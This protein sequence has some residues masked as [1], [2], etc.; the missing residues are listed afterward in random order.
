[1]RL[2]LR[3]LL[4][5]LDNTLD[6]QDAEIL[7]SKLA[8]SG[9]ATQ[10]V[11]RI[12]NLLTRSDLSAPSPLARGPVEEANV[13]C[14]YLDSTL[15]VEQVAEV[16]RACLDSDPHLA[17]A[18]ACHQILTMALENPANV[19]VVLRDRIYQ[20][21]S[22][23][24]RAAETGGSF[25]ALEIPESVNSFDS[26][27]SHV[28]SMEVPPPPDQEPVRPAG[29]SDSGVMAAPARF[30]QRE[31]E[32]DRAAKT[33]PA[34]AGSR[35][36]NRHTE[37]SI[38][39][40][41]VRPSRI[42][43]WLVTLG[44]AGVLLYAL[45]QIF[46]PLLKSNGTADTA[47]PNGQAVT[48]EEDDSETPVEK[49][50][51]NEGSSKSASGSGPTD[52]DLGNAVG[53]AS[54]PVVPDPASSGEEATK[55]GD[56]NTDIS[57]GSEL[58]NPRPEMNPADP[59]VDDAENPKPESAPSTDSDTESGDLEK[60]PDS[61]VASP[62]SKTPEAMENPAG[63]MEKD[64]SPDD[65][66][67][68]PSITAQVL[69]EN[70]LLAVE[71][72]G[73]WQRLDK[74]ADVAAGQPLVVAPGFRASLAFADSEVTLLGPAAATLLPNGKGGLLVRLASGRLLVSSTTPESPVELELGDEKYSLELA[75]PE[76]SAAIQLGHT[77]KPSLDPLLAENHVPVRH[78]I[79]LKG[80]VK[81]DFG[82]ASQT[83]DSGSQ[84]TQ[85]GGGEPRVE[86]L[87]AVPVWAAE[88][89]AD[90]NSLA[91]TARNDLLTL[92]DGAS[93]LEIGL[94]ELLGFRRSEVAALAAQT[95][96]GLGRS[97]VYFG[98]AGVFN[99]LK[100]RAYWSQHYDALLA[101]VDS[102][103]ESA[104]E[105]QQAIKKMDA[106]AEL[107]LFGML[108]GYTDEQ[109]ASGSDRQLL[110]NLDS[111]DM[112]VRVLAFENL[113]RITGVTFNYR[114]EQDSQGRREQYLKRW[115]V[116]QRKG[117]I[118]WKK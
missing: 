102:G 81:I 12:R 109:L 49:V 71:K 50:A 61:A 24:K 85:V 108:T 51:A 115:Q 55:A 5:Y 35:P 56:A 76:T 30:R 58:E 10:M 93:S 118:R 103:V 97:D 116:L 94:R 100:Q 32:D 19:T 83:L 2:T 45:S 48:G 67:E 78:V 20:L 86:V 77:R 18:A 42:T 34:I 72:E 74:D 13:I 6:P 23:Q 8:E 79:A 84:W 91:V 31:L 7:K 95:L 11:Q 33:E 96:L 66:G 59:V 28:L 106:A 62:V 113:R 43:P 15:P 52:S 27:S 107:Q 98:G 68:S 54:V 22:E 40:G 3:T 80:A 75:T 53:D 26:P 63:D 21:P 65:E 69:S 88:P 105:V 46:Q 101:R 70:T 29:V 17:E 9:F 1:M 44:L 112:S 41:Q 39:G 25:S 89:V 111:A 64:D 114:A 104:A 99:D 14:E 82:G 16:E 110:E 87:G 92:L 73:Q 47:N 37:S 117:E 57:E 38:Y 60:D 36:I 4:A 90:A